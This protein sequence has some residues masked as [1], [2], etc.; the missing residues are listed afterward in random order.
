MDE[1]FVP[2]TVPGG[3]DTWERDGVV[4]LP[5]EY[6]DWSRQNAR[7]AP[8]VVTPSGNDA[9]LEPRLRVTSPADGDRYWVPAGDESR[10]AT[11][12]LRA[13]G[14]N[15]IRWSVDGRAHASERLALVPGEHVIRA[16]SERGE[17]VDVRIRVERQ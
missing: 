12:P 5:D 6:A 13:A 1:W 3:R 9:T 14:A 2:G 16:V 11:I 15:H 17:T 10:Y 4:T 8:A 7:I